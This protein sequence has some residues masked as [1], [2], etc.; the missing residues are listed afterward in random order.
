MP[1]YCPACLNPQTLVDKVVE[2]KGYSRP[3]SEGDRRHKRRAKW[4]S[5]AKIESVEHVGRLVLTYVCSVCGYEVVP[6]VTHHR[7]W[8][9]PDHWVPVG[10]QV[11]KG[12]AGVD[13]AAYLAA[14][15]VE[16][17]DAA[18]QRKA[19]YEQRHADK[20]K[21]MKA[22][23]EDLKREERKAKKREA[24]RRLRERIRNGIN[25]QG[26]EPAAD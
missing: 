14:W 15:E 20:R 16:N 25:N 2:A 22:L 12:D 10:K 4:L 11:D 8:A 1:D 21:A 7:N 24:M 9:N 18:K 17:P 3:L 23:Y 6:G 19:E 5:P 13:N 26:P